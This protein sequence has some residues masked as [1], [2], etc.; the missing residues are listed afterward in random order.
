MG[1]GTVVTVFALLALFGVFYIAMGEGVDRIYTKNN[2][3]IASDNAYS[4]QRYDAM[5]AFFTAI[6][7]FPVI[8]VFLV[9]FWSIKQAV[10]NK[11]N[12]I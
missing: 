9:F 3:M 10:K 5:T 1:I 2:E 4:Q 8:L 11:D 6:Y 12:V 7:A